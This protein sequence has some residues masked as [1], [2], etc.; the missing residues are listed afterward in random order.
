MKRFSF[1]ALAALTL[2]AVLALVAAPQSAFAQGST[3][4][5][6]NS[7]RRS[8]TVR[9]SH[10]LLDQVN[11]T[12]DQQTQIAR[13]EAETRAQVAGIRKNKSL[14]P[15]QKKAEEKIAKKA[16]AQKSYALLSP[17]QKAKLRQLR[18]QAKAARQTGTTVTA[19]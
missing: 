17:D 13:F 6:T 1:A 10:P 14:T 16:G 9:S 8:T 3:I 7:A 18:G 11:L 5:T 12:T 19:P 2:A 15:A 4:G